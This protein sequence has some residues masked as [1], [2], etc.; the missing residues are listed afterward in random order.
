M[1]WPKR[2]ST[3]ASWVF[4]RCRHVRQPTGSPTAGTT[5]PSPFPD[6]SSDIVSPS[7]GDPKPAALRFTFNDS[8]S[9]LGSIIGENAA[10]AVINQVNA[11]VGNK[12]WS[13]CWTGSPM[14]VQD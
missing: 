7:G 6:F 5:S 13:R 10:R 12:P 2:W 1:R 14:P 4:T 8:N 11:S 9:Y 3:P